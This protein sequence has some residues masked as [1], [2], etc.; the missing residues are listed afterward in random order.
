M[1][2]AHGDSTANLFELARECLLLARPEAKLA[3]TEAVFEAWRRGELSLRSVAVPDALRR[4]G[5]P[6][7]LR[8]VSPRDLPRR[9]LHTVEGH[10]ALLHSVA[11]IEFN[12]INLAWDAIHRFRDLPPAYY[13]DW[14]QV[15]AEEAIHFRLLRQ[16]LNHLGFDYGDF[17]AHDGLWQAAL[18]TADDPLT[19]MA[20][21]PRVLEARGLDVTPGM[22]QRL[23]QRGDYQA[24]RILD[25]ILRDEIGHVAAGTR[26][27]RYLCAQRRQDP[28]TTFYDLI[29]RHSRGSIKPPFHREARLAA[30][31]TEREL[32]DLERLGDSG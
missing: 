4:P 21:V 25:V 28:E 26:W 3:Q 12:A 27:F 14:L 23:G 31:F 11:H 24:Q 17:P 6:A 1:R 22:R 29:T 18:D 5:M 7:G 19:R 9:R 30:G 10:A 2:D 20:L 32:R 16:H 8:L 15:A 13:A